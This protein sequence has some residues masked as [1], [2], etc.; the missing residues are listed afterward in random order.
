MSVLKTGRVEGLGRQVW[1]ESNFTAAAVPPA[2]TRSHR[3]AEAWGLRA[4]P[5]AARAANPP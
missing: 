4:V 3:Q 5:I 2:S 1:L